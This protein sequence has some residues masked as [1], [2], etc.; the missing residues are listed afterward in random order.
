M[1]AAAYAFVIGK[2]SV[3]LSFICF[4]CSTF[5]GS[6]VLAYQRQCNRGQVGTNQNCLDRKCTACWNESSM[7]CE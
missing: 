3:C 6:S 1:V 4:L 5:L 2:T 7:R